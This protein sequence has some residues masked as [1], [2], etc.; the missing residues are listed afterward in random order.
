MQY[1]ELSSQNQTVTTVAVAVA[2]LTPS[3]YLRN[4]T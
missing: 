2:I 4:P 3:G 1:L